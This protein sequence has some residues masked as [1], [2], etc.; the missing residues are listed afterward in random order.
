MLSSGKVDYFSAAFY[1]RNPMVGGLPQDCLSIVRERFVGDG[2]Q[3]TIRIQNQ[4]MEAQSAS[5]SASRWLRLRGHHVG[6]GARLL[7]RRP[8]QRD[9][10]P[11]AGTRATS[12]PS[13][14]RFVIVDSAATNGSG[15][16]TQV[17]VS[18]PGGVD[19]TRSPST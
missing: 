2:M 18:V 19:G 16:R 13:E 6:E 14:N 3:D 9:A 4:S 11:A 7:P 10:A 15:A 5:P 1:L 8:A 12:T 17:N